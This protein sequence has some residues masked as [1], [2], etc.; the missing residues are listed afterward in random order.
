MTGQPRGGGGDVESQILQ[1]ANTLGVK[2]ADLSS[3]IR[4]LIDP[5][6]PNPAEAAK[7]AAEQEIL[8]AKAANG[9]NADPANDDAGPGILAQMGEVLLD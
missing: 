4:P 2:P 5:S 8:K 3:A 1:L 9:G 7:M 6:A